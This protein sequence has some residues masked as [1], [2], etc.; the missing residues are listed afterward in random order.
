M[1]YED[2]SLEGGEE[3]EERRKKTAES[4]L[5][6]DCDSLLQGYKRHGVKMARWLCTVPVPAPGG[7]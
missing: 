7:S 6:R 5:R 4:A 1:R 2:N 3:V